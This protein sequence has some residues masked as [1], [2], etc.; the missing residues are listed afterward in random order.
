MVRLAPRLQ[1]C[2]RQD[3]LS[4]NSH[5]PGVGGST[6]RTYRPGNVAQRFAFFREIGRW[7]KTGNSRV[8]PPRRTL[9]L[10]PAGSALGERG[11]AGLPGPG[12]P[13]GS[14][15]VVVVRPTFNRRDDA[16]FRR[17]HPPRRLNQPAPTQLTERHTRP[18]PPSGRTRL[19]PTDGKTGTAAIRCLCRRVRTLLRPGL[20]P[21]PPHGPSRHRRCRRNGAAR[22]HNVGVE[23]LDYQQ[24]FPRFSSTNTRSEPIN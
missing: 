19:L 17:R 24:E 14:P 6:P 4:G 22:F 12:C 16:T 20:P 10:R 3:S 5:R 21:A 2:N 13:P 15:Q 18:I 23:N 7:G 8:F 9:G 11:N 1:A